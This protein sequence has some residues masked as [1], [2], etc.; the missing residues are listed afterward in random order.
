MERWIS[1]P[2]VEG[3]MLG[4]QLRASR[5][6]GKGQAAVA[7]QS[8][9][10]GA[11]ECRERLQLPQVH[12]LMLDATL[13]GSSSS[14][15]GTTTNTSMGTSLQAGAA[16]AGAGG[17]VR[18]RQEGWLVR[19]R[20]VPTHHHSNH[21]CSAVCIVCTHRKMSAEV[22]VSCVRSRLHQASSKQAGQ[23]TD[24]QQPA[25]RQAGLGGVHLHTWHPCMPNAMQ[26]STVRA[27]HT[28]RHTGT[29][30]SSSR[31]AQCTWSASC[32]PQSCPS[33]GWQS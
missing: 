18:R 3:G 8:C 24:Q 19:L 15:K 28:A 31:Q 13:T 22:R 32:P 7:E 29:A 6:A 17:A 27:W 33:A 26:H 11:Q 10:S 9:P 4:R 14:M 23:Q 12:E 25:N 2:V 20:D 5:P 30:G 16:D 1:R 21:P